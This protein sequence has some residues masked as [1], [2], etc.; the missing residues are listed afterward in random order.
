MKKGE[1]ELYRQRFRMADKSFTGSVEEGRV[2]EL[3]VQ[4]HIN[5]LCTLHVTHVEDKHEEHI[6]GRDFIATVGDEEAPHFLDVEVKTAR[7]F[8]TRT[9]DHEEVSGTIGFEL[10]SAESLHH[11]GWLPKMLNP[12]DSQTVCPDILVFL[13]VAY[14]NAF[15]CVSFENAH[16]LF[17][18]LR[19]IA[20]A[21]GFDLDHLPVGK[22]AKAFADSRLDIVENMWLVPL[23]Q[24]K[25]LAIVT[26]IGERPRLRPD[27]Y[28]G[29]NKKERICTTATQRARYNY[30]QT[31][32]GGRET[33]ETD[34]EFVFIGDA[35]DQVMST[36]DHNLSFLDSVN[37]NQY[38]CIQ[39]FARKGKFLVCY[40]GVL[41]NML[42]HEYPSRK[43]NKTAYYPMSYGSIAAWCEQN[44]YHAALAT[45][46]GH[47]KYMLDLGLLK[48]SRP[49]KKSNNPID[50]AINK[51]NKGPKSVGYYT[52]VRIDENTFIEADFQAQEYVK[53]RGTS[54]N[55]T[56]SDFIE[57]KGFEKANAAYGNDGRRISKADEYVKECVLTSI[58]LG[59]YENSYITVN[60][61]FR[62]VKSDVKRNQKLYP[63]N[64]EKMDPQKQDKERDR[65]RDYYRAIEKCRKKLKALVKSNFPYLVVHLIS[66][67]DRRWLEADIPNG[68]YI[69]TF[70]GPPDIYMPRYIK[71]LEED[72]KIRNAKRREKRRAKKQSERNG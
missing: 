15:A 49:P 18:R 57:A 29:E 17:S 54:S 64:I 58:Q 13:L 47:I 51:N 71:A 41:E 26:M 11:L 39:Y 45:W 42:S 62:K 22:Q 32:S 24:I 66:K 7:D 19:E 72:E 21:D 35:A 6:E 55:V 43:M 34:N 67:K 63:S 70:A 53:Y 61:L 1:A 60:E 25:D 27:I 38:Q 59:V 69:I 3:Y 68:T 36:I 40:R 65:Q 10:W 12:E 52:P 9:N 4:K 44:G 23:T 30:L 5:E 2:G 56:K 48:Y 14:E 8:I 37:L 20:L 50:V 16:A 33:I 46:Y 31:L 28:S